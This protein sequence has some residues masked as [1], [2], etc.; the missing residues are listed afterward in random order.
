M[1]YLF[2]LLFIASTFA[3]FSQTIK[4]GDNLQVEFDKITTPFYFDAPHFTSWEEGTNMLLIG[5]QPN[6]NDCDV[7]FIALEDTTLIGIYN[8]NE[9]TFMFDIEGTSLLSKTTPYFL[10]P[11]WTVKTN[12]TID[13]DDKRILSILNELYEKTLQA[14]DFELDASMIKAYHEYQKNTELPNRHIALLFDNYQTIVTQAAAGGEQAPPDICIPLM[15]SLSGECLSLYKSIPVI[16]C[17]YMG[18]ALLNAGMTDLARDHFKMSLEFYPNSIPLLVYNY[19]LE[20]DKNSK[21]Q[22]LKKLKKKY[23]KH[24]MVMDL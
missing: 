14:N 15:K 16:V 2:P 4:E 7:L 1:K 24:W 12:A 17:I 6:P 8:S 18:E 19:K 23:G 5:G 20:K 22:Q 9:A 13:S 11:L 10:L 21:D 3:S